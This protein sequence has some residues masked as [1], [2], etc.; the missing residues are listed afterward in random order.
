MP[1]Y[2]QK[3]DNNWLV[4]QT[5]YGPPYPSNVLN[6]GQGFPILND[7]NSPIPISGTNLMM[8]DTN[9]KLIF[10]SNGVD[11][12]DA[13]NH[14]MVNGDSIYEGYIQIL[15]GYPEH[16]N[17]ISVP[18]PDEQGKYVL[19]YLRLDSSDFIP[20]GVANKYFF[21]SIID[22]NLQQG[23]GEVVEKNQLIL[24]SYF[25]AYPAV[26]KHG[27]GRDWWIM[28]PEW[29]ESKYNTH[30]LTSEG[31][32]GPWQQEIGYKPE[33]YEDRDLAGTKLFT[34]DGKKYIDNDGANG[35]RLFDFDRCTGLLSNPVN[36]P[37]AAFGAGPAVASP[38]SRY[39]YTNNRYFIFQYDLL[40]D[41]ICASMDTVAYYDGTHYIK[42]PQLAPDGKI[43]YQSY[44]SQTL[45]VM[46][47]PDLPGSLCQVELNAVHIYC[48]NLTDV[49]YFPNYR[50][51][52][53]PGSPCDTLGINDPNV[54]T[55][56]VEAD[57]QEVTLY[58]NP[59]TDML[60][61]SLPGYTKNE[62]RY[63]ITDPTGRKVAEGI[64]PVF[65]EQVS[66]VVK[67]LVEGMY[68]ISIMEDGT[69][70]RSLKFVKSSG[71]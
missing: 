35:I 42:Q 50:L 15:N 62:V 49:P 56:E 1:L 59:A 12:S 28:T 52:D 3:Y 53:L 7:V 58:P 6:F 27:N 29:F 31:V 69:G 47:N 60:Y 57:A 51:Y 48:E 4:C 2:C 38:N 61:L 22:M 46:H 26:V 24:T 9:G 32:T 40:A 68:F 33:A 16:Q 18:Y 70:M 30:L 36:C 14:V 41:D 23:L 8:S 71:E 44:L 67:G 21:Y 39:L 11:I 19:F 45:H 20:I 13:S 34:P 10:Y 5:I 66:V 55:E 37:V 65:R 64:S 17:M 54:A 25:L 63:N 43:Y